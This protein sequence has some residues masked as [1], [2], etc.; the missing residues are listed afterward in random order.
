[1]MSPALQA[2]QQTVID[3]AGLAVLGAAALIVLAAAV[4]LVFVVLAFFFPKGSPHGPVRV[5]IRVADRVAPPALSAVRRAQLDLLARAERS[6]TDLRHVSA[7]D[8][9]LVPFVTRS[10]KKERGEWN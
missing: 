7:P 9:R 4:L 10:A 8:G 1:M 2:F 5:R 6:P 3:L